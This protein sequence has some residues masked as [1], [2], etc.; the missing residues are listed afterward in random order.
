MAAGA[1]LGLPPE[2]SRFCRHTPPPTCRS[3][4][5]APRHVRSPKAAAGHFEASPAPAAEPQPGGPAAWVGRLLQGY[6]GAL[7]AHPVATKALTSLVGF[8]LGDVLAQTMTHAPFDPI[9]YEGSFPPAP[10]PGSRPPLLAALK[11]HPCRPCHPCLC[12]CL[13]LS[14]YGLF[15]DGPG[16]HVWY[17]LLDERVLPADP[18]NN[19]AVAIKTAADQVVWAP[20]MTV[21]FFAVLKLLEG[22]PDQIVATIQASGVAGAASCSAIPSMGSTCS[23]VF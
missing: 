13:R 5:G 14:T 7:E 4:S 20:V 18:Q 23:Q 19:L 8:A 6:N 3:N 11:P 22:H 15:V 12:R 16:G 1:L 2:P 21:V 9:R 17:K 10:P